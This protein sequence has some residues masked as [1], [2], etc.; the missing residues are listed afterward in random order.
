M[1]PTFGREKL[2]AAAPADRE[3]S[4]KNET[5]ARAATWSMEIR[6][7]EKDSNTSMAKGT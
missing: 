2:S 4:E 5:M 6:R 7:E 3:M 1:Q